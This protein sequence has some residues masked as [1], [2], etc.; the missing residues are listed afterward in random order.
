MLLK[1]KIQ[2]LYS[3]FLNHPKISIDSRKIENRVIYFA[4]KGERF[5]GN[6]FASQALMDGA[7][8]AVIDNSNYY[9]DKRTILVDNVLTT[10]QKLANYHIRQLNIPVLAITGTNGKT[11]T[12]E[13]IKTVLAEKYHV[14][15]TTGNLNNHIGVPLT[16]LSITAK[17]NFAVIEMGANHP[18]EIK[19]LCHIAEPKF[20]II[21]NIGKAHL[22]G[23]GG[24]DGVVKTKKELYDFLIKN[25]GTIFYNSGNPLLAEL[26]ENIN[27]PLIS[28]GNSPSDL[29]QGKIISANPFIKIQTIV[30][31]ETQYLENIINTQLIGVYNLE[32]V[33]AAITI[34]T[35]FKIPLE[36]IKQALENYYPVNNRSQLTKTN[37]NTLIL[38]CYNAN[39]SSTDAALNNLLLLENNNK[40][41]ILGDM[42][43]LGNDSETEHRK[44]LE[45]LAKNKI[46]AILTGPIYHKLAE[47]FGFK[48]FQ[49]SDLLYDWLKSNPVND[50]LIL[51]KGSRGIK[52][53]KIIDLL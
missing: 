42:L 43:E 22:E 1:L 3:I 46:N 14:L 44:I 2:D 11:T 47:A 35:F 8:Y 20:G 27:I 30:K 48:S 7:S 33:L 5:D 24:F 34:G 10:L 52:L 9:I 40:L 29:C 36:N 28:Y 41:A 53:E 4:L 38:D 51:I 17:H 45:F 23:F 37:H 39:P 31:H 13:L 25:N 15:S 12:K 32:N 6:E 16:L 26:L 21:T 50:F 18:N 49:N 19:T